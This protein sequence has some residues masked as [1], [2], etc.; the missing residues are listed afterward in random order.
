MI[1]QKLVQ[2]GSPNL[3][4]TW[5]T[6][7]PGNPFILGSKMSKVKVTRYRA[8]IGHGRCPSVILFIR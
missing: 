1:S 6:M 3:A 5:Y 4:K 7:S 2:L 8:R